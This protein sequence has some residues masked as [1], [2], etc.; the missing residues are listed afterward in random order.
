MST[1]ASAR[2]PPPG[3][4]HSAPEATRGTQQIAA[5]RPEVYR[6]DE[7]E[8]GAIDARGKVV[9]PG[10]I[11]PRTHFSYEGYRGMPRSILWART[12][13]SESAS[14]LVGAGEPIAHRLLERGIAQYYQEIVAS[15]FKFYMV[16]RG[17]DAKATAIG[18]IPGAM[19]MVH[20]QNLDVIARCGAAPG[21]RQGRARDVDGVAC[22]LRGGGERAALS[23]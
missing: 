21:R 15:S 8:G 2:V 23:R 5:P 11:D 10:A 18:G 12:S 13:E 3:A 20:P 14:A 7:A 16:Y 6:F 1:A 4:Y 17:E 9:M 22:G 19:A